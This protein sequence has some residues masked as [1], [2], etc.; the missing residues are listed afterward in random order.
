MLLN[1]MNKQR[2]YAA[3]IGAGAAGMMCAVRAAE[4]HSDKSVM[5]IEKADRV[6]KK[7]LVTG[8]GRCNLSHLGASA[9]SYHGDGSKELINIL[10]KK[11]N[12]KTVTDCFRGLGLFTHADSEGRVYPLSNQSSSVLDVLRKRMAELNIEEYCGAEI[13]GIQKLSNGYEI[14]TPD[15][16]IIAEK[17]VI[18]TGGRADYA[19]RESGSADIL[20]MFGLSV[21]KLSPS[22]SPVKVKSDILRSLKGIRALARVSLIKDNKVIKSESGEVQ[23]TDSALSGICV[24]NLS[25]EANKGGCE[26]AV[27]LLPELDT[28]E[29][30]TELSNR[31]SRSKN[32][33]ISELFVGIFHKNIGIALLKTCGLKPSVPCA[34]ISEKELRKVSNT[35]NNWRFKCEPNRDFNKAQVTAGGVKLSEIDH[36]TFESKKHRGLYIIGEALDIDGDCGGYNLQFAF[37]SGMCAGDSL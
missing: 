5:I 33:P 1:K 10:F 25:R 3:V 11:Y 9:D 4:K 29:I 18:A 23:F 2:V 35:I 24:F 19:G 21:T 8:N 32:A 34:D 7:L 37:A 30:Y 15:R 26:I 13:T 12:D 22:L 28:D 14:V 16:R 6:G 31:A 17:L 20:R 27:S 36:R